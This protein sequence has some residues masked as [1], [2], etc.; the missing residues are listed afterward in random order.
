MVHVYIGISNSVSAIVRGTVTVKC[1]VSGIFKKPH[2]YLL[3][4]LGLDRWRGKSLIIQHTV[5]MALLE[6]RQISKW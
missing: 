4:Y 1:S 5:A 3:T 2:T 6:A